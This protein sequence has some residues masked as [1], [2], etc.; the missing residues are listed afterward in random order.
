MWKNKPKFIEHT[1]IEESETIQITNFA[2]YV[3]K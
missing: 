1:Q 3:Q 2:F